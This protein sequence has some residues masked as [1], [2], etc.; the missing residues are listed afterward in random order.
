MSD[1][2]A[3]NTLPGLRLERLDCDRRNSL[4]PSRSY[5]RLRCSDQSFPHQSVLVTDYYE[6]SSAIWHGIGR[7]SNCGAG[8]DV[9]PF[10]LPRHATASAPARTTRPSRI[11]AC[12]SELSSFTLRGSGDA[13]S[14]CVEPTPDTSH[15]TARVLDATG[16]W[17]SSPESL[18]TCIDTITSCAPSEH[19]R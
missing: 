10:A 18:I 16:T 11:S 6:E 3:A 9:L 1:N 14:E 17:P 15:A 2:V 12:P 19:E 7:G 8:H 13:A 5:C 4:A